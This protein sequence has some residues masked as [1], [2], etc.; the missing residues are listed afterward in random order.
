MGPPENGARRRGAVLKGVGCGKNIS[1]GERGREMW[2][3]TSGRATAGIQ[4]SVGW[5][6]WDPLP[7]MRLREKRPVAMVGF[8]VA[9]RC[10]G[11]VGLAGRHPY[12]CKEG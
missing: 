11:V 4:T 8:S 3:V 5:P 6:G 1:A 10:Q 7:L 2:L 12:S 9:C